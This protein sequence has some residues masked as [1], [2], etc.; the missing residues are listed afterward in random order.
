MKSMLYVGATLMIGASIYGFVDYKKT[1]HAKE[2]TMMYEDP[3]PVPAVVND[4]KVE[5][6]KKAISSSVEPSKKVKTKKEGEE[7]VVSKTSI[8]IEPVETIETEPISI[9]TPEAKEMASV[10]KYKK[11]KKK[12]LGIKSF[13]RA[14]LREEPDPLEVKFDKKSAKRSSTNKE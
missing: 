6:V 14:A 13:S 8:E 5:P 12:R 1:S 2:F 9:T 11:A 7:P 3:Q 4:S 10:E